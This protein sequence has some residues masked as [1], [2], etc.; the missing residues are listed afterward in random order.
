LLSGC[1]PASIA[2]CVFC[3][4]L[5]FVLRPEVFCRYLQAPP[6]ALIMRFF[7]DTDMTGVQLVSLSPNHPLFSCYQL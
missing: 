2:T 7:V 3:T 1:F 5:L 4:L 6:T